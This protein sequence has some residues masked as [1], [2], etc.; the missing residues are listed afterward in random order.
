[1]MLFLYWIGDF[2]IRVR[3]LFLFIVIMNCDRIRMDRFGREFSFVRDFIIIIGYAII[4]IKTCEIIDL[5]I[6]VP[7]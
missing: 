4:F 1:M 6:N 7:H 3:R 5:S 2:D